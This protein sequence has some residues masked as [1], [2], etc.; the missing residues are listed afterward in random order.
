MEAPWIKLRAAIDLYIERMEEWIT[1]SQESLTSLSKVVL[2]ICHGL[3]LFFLQ[4][5]GLFTALREEC[6][7]YL[8]H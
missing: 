7:F 8:N 1:H 3:D 4:E 2:Q 5:E 6:C